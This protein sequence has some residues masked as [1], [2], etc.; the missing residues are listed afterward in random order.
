MCCWGYEDVYLEDPPPPKKPEPD[1]HEYVLMSSDLPKP[2]EAPIAAPVSH[3][4]FAFPDMNFASARVHRSHS[5]T[6]HHYLT[7]RIRDS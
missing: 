6:H 5:P 7:P 1:K 2:V 4:C 3:V